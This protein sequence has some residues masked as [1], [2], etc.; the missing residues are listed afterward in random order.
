MPPQPQGRL[1]FLRSVILRFDPS[2]S[3]MAGRWGGSLD[4]KST[5]TEWTERFLNSTLYGSRF[6]SL[7]EL[8]LDFL[9]MKL[10]ES[11]GFRVSMSS[12]TYMIG[13]PANEDRS[14]H[15]SGIWRHP[16]DYKSL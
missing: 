7:K 1:T 5:W 12:R 2:E 3:Y 15:L 8:T 14:S 11:E 16:S 9:K 10:D 6:P 4:P 13:S